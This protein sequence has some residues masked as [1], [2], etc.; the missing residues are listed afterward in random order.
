MCATIV[1]A[2]LF[3]SLQLYTDNQI[4]LHEMKKELINIKGLCETYPIKKYPD[5][6]NLFLFYI[7]SG[8]NR[9]P[10]C[11]I[12]GFYHRNTE[13]ARLLKV[14]VNQYTIVCFLPKNPKIV[15][16]MKYSSP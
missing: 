9:K 7:S 6:L 14:K 10:W 11:I 5:L 1:F 16:T 3:Y 15:K 8:L 12:L 13:S 4:N 2:F